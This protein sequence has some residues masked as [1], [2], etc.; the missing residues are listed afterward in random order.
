[1]QYTDLWFQD[2]PHMALNEE[3]VGLL[4]ATPGKCLQYVVIEGKLL[5]ILKQ[6]SYWE[7][8][9]LDEF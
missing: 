1:M 8:Y 5:L 4:N 9:W 3:L 7:S 6:E 2:A